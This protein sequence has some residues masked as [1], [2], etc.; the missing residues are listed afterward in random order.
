MKHYSTSHAISGGALELSAHEL[1]YDLAA[2]YPDHQLAVTGLDGGTWTV[3]VRPEGCPAW[4]SHATG[5]AETTVQTVHGLIID[6]LRVTLAGLGG[7]ADPKLYLTSRNTL[8]R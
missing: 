2:G 4:K 1:G 7:A 6:G 3:Q 8:Q 5:L